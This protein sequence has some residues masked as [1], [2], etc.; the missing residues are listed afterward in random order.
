MAVSRC[1]TAVTASQY[2]AKEETKIVHTS[3]RSVSS[4]LLTPTA[5]AKFGQYRS[6][7]G[8]GDSNDSVSK[9]SP[10]S[11]PS[12]QQSTPSAKKHVGHTDLRQIDATSDNAPGFLKPTTATIVSQKQVLENKGKVRHEDDIWWS[13]RNPSLGVDPTYKVS[14]DV[15]SKLYAPTVASAM[16][17]VQ[18]KKQDL[19]DVSTLNATIVSAVSVTPVKENSHFLTPTKAAEYGKWEAAHNCGSF[20]APS[21]LELSEARRLS[22]ATGPSDVS[23]RLYRSTVALNSAKWKSKE[24]IQAEEE[25]KAAAELAKIAVSNFYIYIFCV[26]FNY[27]YSYIKLNFLSHLFF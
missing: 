27:F 24:E 23:S 5:A 8:S 2:H 6:P 20:S 21:K 22:M 12:D 17:Q 11:L 18:K 3:A 1:L 25:A 26:S 15:H 19:I 7:Q 13:K 16:Q 9:T 4:H 10:K 14:A